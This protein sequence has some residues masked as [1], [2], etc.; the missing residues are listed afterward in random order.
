MTVD[1]LR[2][3][4]LQPGW[5]MFVDAGP[6]V[7]IWSGAANFG[8]G[9]TGPDAAGGVYQGLGVIV[10]VPTLKIPL[11]GSFSQHEFALSGVDAQ[12][13]RAFDVDRAVL[14]G[15]NLSW[16]RVE[17]DAS[18]QPIAEPVWLWKGSIDS[19]R[20]A[21][22]GSGSTAVRTISLMTSTGSVTR[23]RRVAAYWSGPQ[24][25]SIDPDDAAC[26]GT[27]ALA[28]GTDEIWPQ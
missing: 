17:L 3:D 27:A 22:D 8:L 9:V 1:Y 15:A 2:G 10:A 19:P 23:K 18:M 16:A 20:I 4:A 25:R 11:N 13:V 21:R 6:G 28:A 5:L 7:R 26:D 12:V 14:Q 24:Q